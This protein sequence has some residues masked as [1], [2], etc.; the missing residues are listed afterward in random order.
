MLVL[1]LG[2]TLNVKQA[3]SVCLMVS[4]SYF[5]SLVNCL[6]WVLAR[7]LLTLSHEMMGVVG[8]SSMSWHLKINQAH[9]VGP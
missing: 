2:E 1:D 5:F 8:W 9:E 7:C 3:G 4:H 6:W